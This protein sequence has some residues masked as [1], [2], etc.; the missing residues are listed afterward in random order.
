MD[1]ARLQKILNSFVAQYQ[2]SHST[3]TKWRQPLMAVASAADP[4][5]VKLKSVVSPSHFLPVDLLCT[6]RTVVTYFI[7]F[8]KSIAQ[9]NVHGHLASEE[10]AR[11]YIET[12]ALLTALGLAMK[13]AI[14]LAGFSAEF[15]PPTHKFDPKILFSDWSH[16]HVA[17]I[18]GLG[19]FGLNNMLITE[20]GC[21][22]R[23]GSFVTSLD[24]PANSKAKDEA[25]LYR[26]NGSCERCVKRCVG[27]ALYTDQFDHYK[28]YKVY[29]ENKKKYEKMGLAGVCG[30]CLVS[31]PCSFIN[32]VRKIQ[33]K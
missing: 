5:F 10:W 32:P 7:P 30:K 26:H 24:L 23:I 11:A 27:N 9:S 22:G 33:E 16:R 13:K 29:L 2:E 19:K 18:A 4:L 3:I 31:T 21:C 20:S 25:C 15:T 17:Y 12:N 14:E 6:A 28:C 1:K 8:E